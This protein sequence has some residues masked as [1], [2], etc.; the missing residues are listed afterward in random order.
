MANCYEK[1]NNRNL[2]TN[3]N[4]EREIETRGI[5]DKPKNDKINVSKI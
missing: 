2:H 5:E 3:F 4:I 1:N